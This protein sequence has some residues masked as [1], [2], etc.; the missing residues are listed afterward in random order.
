[1]I[2]LMLDDASVKGRLPMM[3]PPL[4]KVNN[5]KAVTMDLDIIVNF[6]V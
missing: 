2:F 4:S 1:M 3:V 6:Y 5:A